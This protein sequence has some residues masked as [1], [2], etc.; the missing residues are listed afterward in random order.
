LA[1]G[2]AGVALPPLACGPGK[3]GVADA[4]GA[5]TGFFTADEA[6]TLARLADFVLPPDATYPGGSALGTVPYVEQLLTS[7]EGPTPQVFRGGPYSGRAP[8]VDLNGLPTTQDPPDD[9]DDFLPLDRIQNAAWMLR[10]YG[11][12]G[13]PGGGPNDA[14]ADVG[15][16]IGFQTQMKQALDQ[17]L[18]AAP[19]IAT[20]TD[21]QVATVWAG[22]SSAQSALITELVVEAC[23]GAPEYGGN[24]G[25]GGWQLSHF[26]GD[27]TPYGYSQWDQTTSAYVQRTDLPLTTQDTTADPDPLD[28]STTQLLDALVVATGGSKF[29]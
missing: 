23:F 3:S 6:A 27:Q 17:V 19:G 25:L 14:V 29:S 8:F 22:L 15:P 16:T 24:V 7:M 5:A 20:M 12:S 10:I 11:S 28:P 13:V 26:P 2:A 18:A 4:G 1:V 9:F 21:A